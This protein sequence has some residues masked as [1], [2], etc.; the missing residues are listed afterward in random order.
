MQTCRCCNTVD[1][2]HEVK[3]PVLEIVGKAIDSPKFEAE[4][5]AEL[6]ACRDQEKIDQLR[7]VFGTCIDLR[8][9]R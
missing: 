5:S 2:N 7:K 6:K 9:T 1:P 8:K 3:S 4:E